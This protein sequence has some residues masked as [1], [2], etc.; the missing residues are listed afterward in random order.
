MNLIVSPESAPIVISS[1]AAPPLDSRFARAVS[2]LLFET[3]ST[4]VLPA[5][6]SVSPVPKLGK[7][8]CVVVTAVTWPVVLDEIAVIAVID[9]PN[10]G[11]CAEPVVLVLET[12]EWSSVIVSSV[13]WFVVN[14]PLAL[15][16]VLISKSS[17]PAIVIA[18]LPTVIP[19]LPAFV[20]LPC[21]STVKFGI[22]VLEPY[23]P[24]VTAVSSRSISIVEPE[25]LVEIPVSP[26]IV[27][28]TAPLL[29]DI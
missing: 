14:T 10:S 2:N 17:P 20:I 7:L 12:E 28:L 19:L 26:D 24:A 11:D 13:P 6:A 18:A 1:S 3:L 9:S 29:S 27:K 15:L 25:A 21:A 5:K 23:V 8:N 16:S 22:C 4:T